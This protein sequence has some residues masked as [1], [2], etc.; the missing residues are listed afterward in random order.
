MDRHVIEQKLESL[1]R[2]LARIRLRCPASV[3]QFLGDIDAQDIVTLNL[4]RAIQLSVDIAANV[5][6]GTVAVPQTMGETFDRLAEAKQIAP[7]LALR[8][9]RAVGFRNLAVHNYDAIDWAIVHAIA[10]CNLTDF[11]DFARA[12]VTEISK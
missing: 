3:E 7:E 1:R 10:T 5:L 12:I 8:L 9:R 4:T 6:P 11:D 2:C